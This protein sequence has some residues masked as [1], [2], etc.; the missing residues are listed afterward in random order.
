MAREIRLLMDQPVA[1]E[2]PDIS[3]SLNT[4]DK[5]IEARLSRAEGS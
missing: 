5:A 2:I 1:V 4:L 3:R